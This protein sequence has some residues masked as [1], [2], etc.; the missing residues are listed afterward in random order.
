VAA[1]GVPLLDVHRQYDEL[2]D[3]IRTAM[4][5]V[6]DS[7]K[8]I[9][10]PECTA[11]EQ[12]VAA[13]C[14]ASHAVGCASGSDALLLALLA[15]DIG[16]GDEVIVPSYTF[17]ATA[18]AVWRTGAKIVFAEIDPDTF[19]IDAHHASSLVTSKTKAI[20]PVHLFGQCAEMTA[21][22]E[23]AQAHK[24]ALI[25]DAAQAIGAEY[26]GR[27]A[28]S[29]GDVGCLSFYP[30]KNLG[31]F[32]DGGMLTTN[33]EK[34]AARLRL[35]A[36]HGMSPRYYHQVVGVN[37][38]LDSLQACV[39]RVKLPHLERWS[40][41]R[42]A[43][44]ARYVE[45]FTERGLDRA[46]QMPVVAEGNRHVWNQFVIRVHEDRRDAL[47][48]F[49]TENSIGSEI[50]YPVP[51]HQQECFRSLGYATGCLPVTEQAA[52][53]T[54]ALPIFPELTAAEQRRVVDRI[55]E[56]FASSAAK[57]IHAVEKTPTPK[58]AGEKSTPEKA[59]RRVV[60]KAS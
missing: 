49:L 23:L 31:G 28:G 36:S 22:T 40:D 32:G 33:D 52:L 7:G 50:Y 11:L 12:E 30:T 38:R 58:I 21:L 59:P 41:A 54:M 14:Q 16:A 10:G 60:R 46:V 1:S 6:C 13:Y 26:Q 2:R 43:N 53:E 17:F 29:M 37:S 20:I 25:E 56:F 42:T 44:A 24:I 27:R 34:F 9:N 39:L 19:N 18:S 57:K 5:R 55:A 3:D 48:A 35:Y 51:L 15:L 8:F 47:R 4:D 45:L